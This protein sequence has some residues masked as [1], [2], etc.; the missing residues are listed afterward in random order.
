M[1]AS[2]LKSMRDR[3][4]E[5]LERLA[6]PDK[7]DRGAL[8]S[9]R[10]GL[11]HS[12]WKVTQMHR[13]VVP[14]RPSDR[15]GWAEQSYYVLAAL[16]ALHPARGGTGNF[17]DTFRSIK[18]KRGGARGRGANTGRGEQKTSDSLEQRFVALLNCCLDDLHHHLRQAVSLAKAEDVPV[19]WR[20][21][22]QHVIH[23]DDEEGWVQRRWAQAFWGREQ[24]TDVEE[25]TGTIQASAT[26]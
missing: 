12:P 2:P 24:E 23:W 14:F 21:L 1:D 9:L 26:A 3:F 13:Y 17:G 7:P 19:D 4:W 25:P 22:H 16:F 6:D 10:R 8:A 11:G 15:W 18:D 20:Q 5:Q